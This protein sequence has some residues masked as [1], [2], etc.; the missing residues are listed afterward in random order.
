QLDMDSLQLYLHVIKVLLPSM[1]SVSD[2]KF[3]Q[4]DDSDSDDEVM[5]S[6]HDGFTTL[7]ALR[8]KCLNLLST[9][10]HTA[11]ILKISS[12]QCT[13]TLLTDLC[14]LCHQLIVRHRQHVPR[15]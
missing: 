13:V 2:R 8:E 12:Q 9:E 10:E 5:I 1:P 3:A 7:P 11:S 14:V 4:N 6:E 15:T